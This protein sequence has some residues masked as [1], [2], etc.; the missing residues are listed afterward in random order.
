MT[1]ICIQKVCLSMKISKKKTRNVSVFEN[2]EFCKVSSFNI[3]DFFDFERF[4]H[5]GDR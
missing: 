1:E 2:A 5:D 4:P 3:F